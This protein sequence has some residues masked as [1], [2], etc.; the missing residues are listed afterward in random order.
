MPE[1][2]HRNLQAHFQQCQRSRNSSQ[3]SQPLEGHTQQAKLEQP[4]PRQAHKQFVPPPP[5]SPQYPAPSIHTATVASMQCSQKYSHS[6]QNACND[7]QF[8]TRTSQLDRDMSSN[9]YGSTRKT[10]I[11]GDNKDSFVAQK[12]ARITSV[13]V[14]NT[15][16]LHNQLSSFF[17][18][19]TKSVEKKR[20]KLEQTES[21]R[22][23]KKVISYLGAMIRFEARHYM[24]MQLKREQ[25]EL[26]NANSQSVTRQEGEN[27]NAL[28]QNHNTSKFRDRGP[29][30]IDR[31]S[32]IR[33]SKQD[34]QYKKVSLVRSNCTDI[35]DLTEDDGMP[36]SGDG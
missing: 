23:R 28:M 27:R 35:I 29:S 21:R 9:M 26:G 7:H 6:R 36:V 3:Q 22:P 25:R 16:P 33:Q 11:G 5:P 20:M 31:K 8:P 1:Q 32:K 14:S 10:V 18:P 2:S 34:S 17:H 4:Q 19:T 13:G 24:K 30:F 15:R 12:R